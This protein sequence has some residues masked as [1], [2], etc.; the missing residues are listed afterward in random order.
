MSNARL[1]L[2]KLQVKAKKHPEAE[3]LYM[4]IIYFFYSLYHPKIIGDI[5]ENV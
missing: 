4:K 2:A 5:L 1:K 3:P